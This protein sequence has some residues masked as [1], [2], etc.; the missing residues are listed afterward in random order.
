MKEQNDSIRERY[1]LAVWRVNEIKKE[2]SVKEPYRD[3]FLKVAAF[4][5]KV[6]GFSALTEQNKLKDLSLKELQELN[7]SLYEDILPE[8]YE[9]SYAN[10]AY[11][12]ERLGK[13]YGKILRRKEWL[14]L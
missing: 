14:L 3:Y 7:K 2:N 12:A 4:I 1:E 10:P 8:N 9:S 6:V 5:E 11:A 13:K